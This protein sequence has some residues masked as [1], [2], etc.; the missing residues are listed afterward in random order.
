MWSI[1]K[2]AMGWGFQVRPIEMLKI[3]KLRIWQHSHF[4]WIKESLLLYNEKLAQSQNQQ[5]AKK[6][7]SR[8]KRLGRLISYDYLEFWTKISKNI[9][10]EIFTDL[11]SLSYLKIPLLGIKNLTWVVWHDSDRRIVSPFWSLKSSRER[12]L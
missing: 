2:Q 8:L 1:Q 11:I 9:I 5:R 7:F 3:T 10:N 6:R 12:L 4:G